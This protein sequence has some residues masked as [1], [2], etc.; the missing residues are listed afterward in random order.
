MLKS[1]I[2]YVDDALQHLP[3]FLAL[4]T[5]DS[6]DNTPQQ[7]G[8]KHGKPKAELRLVRESRREIAYRNGKEIVDSA[9]TDPGNSQPESSTFTGFTTKGEF[10]PVLRQSSPTRSREASFGI[11][12]KRA[13]QAV[14]LWS[15]VTEFQNLFLTM[16]STFVA[17]RNPGTIHNHLDFVTWLDITANFTWTLRLASWT[18]LRWRR[19]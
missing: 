4:R 16:L 18:G 9:S 11:V 6:F 10:G 12:G 13:N 8:P 3:D 5:T 7:A 1:A 17:I 19:S 14:W 2:E 15:F